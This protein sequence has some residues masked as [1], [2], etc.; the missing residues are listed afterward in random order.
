MKYTYMGLL[1]GLW[2]CNNGWQTSDDGT[3]QYQCI[4]TSAPTP[5]LE[6]GDEAIFHYQILKGD[7]VL[8]QSY[9]QSPLTTSIPAKQFR[10][11]FENAMMQGGAGDSIRVRVRYEHVA[12]LL[13]QYQP[14]FAKNDYVEA[15]FRIY[16]TRP[17]AA[18]DT[19]QQTA[20]AIAKGFASVEAMEAERSQILAQA[21][22][23]ERFMQ[24][25]VQNQTQPTP[26]SAYK[27]TPLTQPNSTVARIK[28]GDTV[29]IY[30][31]G[32]VKAHKIC[33]DNNLQRAD[34][35]RYIVG[36]DS[37]LI[38]V[39]HDAP[40]SMSKGD[41]ALIE[42]PSRWAYGNEGSQ[43]IVPP[44]ADLLIYIHIA[45]VRP[46]QIIQ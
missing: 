4:H 12:H 39:F 29:D 8:E 37:T 34:R 19:D 10:N 11:V 43:P 44:N 46:A 20:Y 21:D 9:G 23:I 33:Y 24:Q 38:Q 27:I 35:L 6:F 41:R 14:I 17:R 15:T 1:L 40:L 42:V 30:Y 25:F 7:S 2:A 28:Q 32:M 36:K 18:I 45:D 31:A 5:R 3:F 16:S 13:T 22:T 26:V